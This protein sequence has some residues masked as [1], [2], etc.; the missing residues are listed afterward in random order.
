MSPDTNKDVISR[1]ENTEKKLKPGFQPF[2]R[3]LNQTA[4]LDGADT[5]KLRAAA[6]PLAACALGSTFVPRARSDY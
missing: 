4:I 1:I 2:V 3:F 6:P 5:L